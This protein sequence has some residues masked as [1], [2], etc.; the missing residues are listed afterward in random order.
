M[1]TDEQSITLRV[2][3]DGDHPLVILLEPW[4]HEIPVQPGTDVNIVE[5][6]G[7]PDQAI[8]IFV[9]DGVVTVWARDGALLD[10]VK[11]GKSLI[12]R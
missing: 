12:Y 8:D 7:Q 4:A 9:K 2:K 10:A 11:D 5:S 1:P 6:N 3:N